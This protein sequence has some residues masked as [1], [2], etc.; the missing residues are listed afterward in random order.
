MKIVR[1]IEEFNNPNDKLNNEYWNYKQNL[2]KMKFS[3]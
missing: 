1:H 3:I 2:D